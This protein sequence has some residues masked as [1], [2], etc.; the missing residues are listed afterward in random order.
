MG[1]KSCNKFLT[2]KQSKPFRMFSL[3]QMKTQTNF[4]GSILHPEVAL[5]KVLTKRFIKPLILIYK[6]FPL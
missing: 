1:H 6:S 4:A 2:K 5:P 3:F